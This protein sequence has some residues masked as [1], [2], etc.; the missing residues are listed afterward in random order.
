M[1]KISIP[2]VKIILSTYN[3]EKYIKE[4]VESVLAQNYPNFHL[5]I[6]DD[7]S[8]DKTRFI[9][10]QYKTLKNVDIC[11]GKNLGVIKSFFELLKIAGD[12]AQYIAFC[13]QDDI[14]KE[15]KITRAVD[16]LERKVPSDIPGLYFC[17]YALVDKNLNIIGYSNA[18]NRRPFFSNALVQNIANGCTMVINQKTRSLLIDHIPSNPLMYDAWIYLLVSAFGR[19]IYDQVPTILYRQHGE[20]TIGAET[21]IIRKWAG[22]ASRFYKSW[23]KRKITSQAIEF[24][25]LFYELMPREKKNIIDNFIDSQA[26][27]MTRI[28]YAFSPEVYRQSRIDNIILRILIL[29]KMI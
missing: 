25:E 29:L 9:L 16:Q 28:H 7:G 20:N 27:F 18:P 4:L 2:K 26:K 13:D 3:G 11:L 22:R 24:R 1:D 5:I 6:R 17:R 21:S 14:W 15:N 8:T 12:D 10:N 19:V 23:G